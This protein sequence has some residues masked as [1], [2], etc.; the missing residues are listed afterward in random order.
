MKLFTGGRLRPVFK[1]Q[2]YTTVV[3]GL[4]V[5]A[6]LA[7]GLFV[8]WSTHFQQREYLIGRAQTISDTLPIEDIKALKGNQSDLSSPAYARVK[9]GLQQVSNSNTDISRIHLF[10]IRDAHVQVAADSKTP[11]ASGYVSPGSNFSQATET[12]R[13]TFKT[14]QPQYDN[15]LSD[16][17]GKWVAAY[18]PVFDVQTGKTIGAVGI[19]K[20]AT[21]YY[22]EV[23]LLSIVPLLLAAIPLAG[24]LRDIKIQAKEHEIMQLKNQFV[25]IASHELRSPLTGMLWGIQILQRD[26]KKLSLK[27]RGLLH[28]M[29]LSTESSLSTVNEILDLSIFERR[30]GHILQ[31]DKLD[32]G[33]VASQVISTLKLGAQEKNIE[34][35][36]NG[37]WPE[38]LYV[39]GDV[40]ALKRGLMNIVANA[41]KYTHE[42]DTVVLTYRKSPEGEHI[43]AIQDHGIGIPH[44]EQHK[45]LSG[46]YRA[47]NASK[48]QAHGTGLGLWLTRKIIM[49]HGGRLWLNSTEGKGTT[50]FVALPDAEKPAKRQ[51]PVK[52]AESNSRDQDS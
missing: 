1:P 37:N 9:Q 43:I 20:D 41:I 39:L 2:K 31:K 33:A 11:D 8:G 36:K 21:S 26:E 23:F 25:S 35:H 49:E 34:I 14:N 18:T 3:A 28:D 47:T 22:L 50:V 27:Q 13:A 30:E 44:D 6:G 7:S 42:H 48:V 29:Y 32:L 45:V 46:Y 16:Y 5:G 10:V 19:F 4:I 15:L 12:L 38:E 51:R 40:G 24:I 17:S 52:S